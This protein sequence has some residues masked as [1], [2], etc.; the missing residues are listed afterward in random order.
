MAVEDFLAFKKLMIR[1][2]AELN[3]E[4]LK[5]MV[6]SEYQEKMYQELEQAH[7]QLAGV[8]NNPTKT[9]IPP[10][11]KQKQVEDNQESPGKNEREDEEL[12]EALRISMMAEE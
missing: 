1:R 3:E 8:L 6:K 12:N 5:M 4:A 9:Y 11:K 10:V 2:N 7:K